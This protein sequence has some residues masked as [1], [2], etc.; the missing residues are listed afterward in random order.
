MP[1]DGITDQALVVDVQLVYDDGTG[2]RTL[3]AQPFAYLAPG[4]TAD[5]ACRT[6]NVNA[7]AGAATDV[8][9]ANG[10]AG[11]GAARFESAQRVLHDPI[12]E[13][14]KRDDDE[15]R[16]RAQAS[17]RGFDE[18][19]ESV[20]L[21]VH[22]DAQG[23][24]RARRGID[25]MPAAA[26]HAGS[27]QIGQLRRR[28]NCRLLAAF[29]DAAGNSPA[30]TLFAVAKNHIGEICFAQPLQDGREAGLLVQEGVRPLHRGDP[31]GC[32]HRV[33]PASR[34]WIP[35]TCRP[36]STSVSS[37]VSGWNLAARMSR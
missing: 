34:P 16:A 13:R 12:L 9:F 8:L 20:E 15:P 32:A 17:H 18:P 31:D 36:S 14:M 22:P 28:S 2:P 30:E 33:A 6:G 5:Y 27:Y 37:I 35:S 10:S 23:L 11:N 26:R 24:K 1:G 4:L 21:A 19:I 25:P 3:E 29:D 7:G